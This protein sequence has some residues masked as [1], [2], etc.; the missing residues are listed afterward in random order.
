MRPF[1]D[2]KD[3]NR[4]NNLNQQINNQYNNNQNNLSK[5]FVLKYLKL[6]IPF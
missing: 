3:R 5:Y 2:E 4:I 1:K 6:L